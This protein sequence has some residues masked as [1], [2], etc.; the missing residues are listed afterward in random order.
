MRVKPGPGAA[1]EPHG[2][3]PRLS[4]SYAELTRCLSSASPSAVPRRG[5]RSLLR[6]G[7][8]VSLRTVPTHGA[9][10]A[11]SKPTL[12]PASRSGRRARRRAGPEG[13]TRAAE[14]RSRFKR[15][16]HVS[17]AMPD[18]HLKKNTARGSLVALRFRIC[19]LVQGMQVQSPAGGLSSTLP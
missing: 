12:G 3:P 17:T 11:D 13:A 4:V 9:A 19:L 7:R 10:S 1:S 6:A 14:S 16:L 15:L 5:D 18:D 8:T 2:P